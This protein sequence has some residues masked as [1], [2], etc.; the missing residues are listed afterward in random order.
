M[1]LKLWRFLNLS[2]RTQIF[3]MKLFQDKFLVGVTGLIFD[4][5]D[6]I[7]LF[8]HTYRQNPW[9]LPGGFVQAHEHPAAA[10]EREI[11]EESGLVISIDERLEIRFNEASSKLDICYLGTFIGGE[12]RKSDEVS[13]FGLFALNDLPL[14]P[15]N[16][17]IL[18]AQALKYK[19]SRRKSFVYATQANR[20]T[21]HRNIISRLQNY[22]TT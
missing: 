3:I 12:F 1:L 8:K 20:Q 19:Q 17:T 5:K 4:E 11:E 18:I 6:R 10:V 9:G 21:H 15:K 7:L 2:G 16:Q 14:I 13:D 22:L